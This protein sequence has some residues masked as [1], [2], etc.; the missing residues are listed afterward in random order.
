MTDTPYRL[1]TREYTG[2][3][4]LRS[5]LEELNGEYE[6]TW[7]WKLKG[8]EY[9]K[10]MW[11]EASNKTFI[12]RMLNETEVIPCEWNQK[13]LKTDSFDDSLYDYN[14]TIQFLNSHSEMV[15]EI[16]NRFLMLKLMLEDEDPQLF[17][18]R[19][20][21]KI[22]SLNEEDRNKAMKNKEVRRA[23]YPYLLKNPQ[24]MT[25]QEIYD[26]HERDVLG[27]IPVFDAATDNW[28]TVSPWKSRA[29]VQRYGENRGW[30]AFQID[31]NVH[32]DGA[33]RFE[34][35]KQRKLMTHQVAQRY[36]L[37]MDYFFAGRFQ[38]CLA[39]NIN[40]RK[41]F[42][43][44]PKEIQRSGTHYKVPKKF[45]PTITSAIQSMEE[46]LRQT[47]IRFLIMDNEPAWTSKTFQ[48][49]LKDQG[50]GY[51]FVVKNTIT[52]DLETHDRR[53]LNHSTTGPID[54]LIRTLRMMNYH[55]GNDNE[56]PPNVM[57]MLIDEYNNSPHS[58]LSKSLK[59]PVTPNE[60]NNDERLERKIIS[61]LSRENFIVRSQPEYKVSGTVRVFNEASRFDKVKPRLLPGHWNVLGPKNGLIEL[62]QNGNR[63][64][65]N[66]WMIKS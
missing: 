33:D 63:I 53:R 40:T 1:G 13:I 61:E 24:T 28:S 37:T 4:R 39:I 50:I 9:L 6:N 11:T 32:R 15:N 46:L 51:Q 30:T 49:F 59:R 65:V 10:G 25:W 34:M 12:N 57:K 52:D 3:S 62:E 60:V 8:I 47:P 22:L 7:W 48:R 64:R 58:T 41:A 29:K 45:K 31:S 27:S 14:R 56:I 54:R 35:K 26:Q 23:L 44:I 19:L 5:L 17:D 55:L 66:R 16:R 43:S 18:E 2:F 42:F 38:Y 20:K 21:E 36:T